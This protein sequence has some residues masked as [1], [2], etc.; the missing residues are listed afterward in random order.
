MYRTMCL[1]SSDRMSEISRSSSRA[2]RVPSS[3]SPICLS[4]NSSPVRSFS[5]RYTRPNVPSPIISPF[6]HLS[7]PDVRRRRRCRR[8]RCSPCRGGGGTESGLVGAAA[9]AA[10]TSSFMT[11]CSSD[12]PEQHDPPSPLSLPLPSSENAP[13]LYRTAAAVVVAAAAA[14][15]TAPLPRA[16]RR[17]AAP[18]AALPSS[19]AW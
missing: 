15:G 3:A 7:V 11:S 2:S 19:S 10:P 8:C 14:A 13:S 9:G 18:W 16:T 6:R 5:A 12:D 17:L 1:C 4:A